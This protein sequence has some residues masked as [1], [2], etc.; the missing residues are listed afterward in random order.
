MRLANQDRI[1]LN[2]VLA[3]EHSIGVQ[4]LRGSVP[5]ENDTAWRYTLGREVRWPLWRKT[6]L[7]GYVVLGTNTAV[8]AGWRIKCP[9]PIIIPNTWKWGG[10]IK[11]V[12]GQ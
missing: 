3:T 4:A 9:R 6:P 1:R 12:G 11:I 2:R 7:V 5:R 10:C 8:A